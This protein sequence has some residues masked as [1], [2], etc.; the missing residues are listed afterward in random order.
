MPGARSRS[1]RFDEWVLG[2]VDGLEARLGDAL[3]GVEFAVEDV[4]PSAPAP[5]EHGAVPLGRYFP[6]DIGLSHRIVIYRRPVEQR[7]ERDELPDLVR[8]VVVEQ[9]AQMLGREPE[10]VDPEYRG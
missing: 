10:D 9:I 8:D 4:P 5:W 2:V 1:E 6:A 3:D 7:A